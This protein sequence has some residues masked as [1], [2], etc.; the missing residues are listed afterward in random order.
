MELSSRD[1]ELLA[2]DALTMDAWLSR[3]GFRSKRLRWYVE[4]ACRDDFGGGLAEVSAWAGLH[5][6]AARG[7]GEDDQFLV[8]PEGNGFLVRGLAD[9]L[10]A[11]VRTRALAYDVEIE[12]GG[13]RVLWYD[14]EAGRTRR[15]RA[16]RAIVCAPRFAARRIVA[17]LREDKRP[18]GF[19]YAPW[20]VANLTVENPP[21]ASAPRR[22]GTT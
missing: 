6:Y 16:K 1:P 15:I 21:P 19:V 8:W 11:R 18:S 9:A 14:A 10:G 12:N 3:E 17:P 7:E 4:Y 5:Y 22:R 2:L 20:F 13:A